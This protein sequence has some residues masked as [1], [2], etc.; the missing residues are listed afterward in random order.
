MKGPLPAASG[1]KVD[2]SGVDQSLEFLLLLEDLAGDP[3]GLGGKGVLRLGGLVLIGLDVRDE[4][5]DCGL[6]LLQVRFPRLQILFLRLLGSAL[7][8]SSTACWS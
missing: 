3:V 6:L 5:V 4:L 1:I 2:L 7:V 8:A